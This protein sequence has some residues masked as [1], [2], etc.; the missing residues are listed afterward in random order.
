MSFQAP[1]HYTLVVGAQ[2]FAEIQ[3][4]TGL[5]EGRPV[6][7]VEVALDLQGLV[8]A[9]ATHEPS[10]VLLNPNLRNYAPDYVRDLLLR[11]GGPI[12]VVGYR[13]QDPTGEGAIMKKQGAAAFFEL[14][15][16]P[17][18]TQLFALIE[19]TYRKTWMAWKNGEFRATPDL[20]VSQPGTVKSAC[21]VPYLPKGG[22]SSRT[23]TASNLAAGLAALGHSTCLVDFDGTKGDVH[24]VFGYTIHPNNPLTPPDQFRLLDRT[25]YDLIME[26]LNNWEPGT[27]I[28]IQHILK[29]ITV[30]DGHPAVGRNLHLLA[31][32]T[33]PTLAGH[34]EW[35][36]KAKL[37]Y[38]LGRAILATLKTAYDFVIADVSQDYNQPLVGAALD[39]A[40]D[41]IMPVPPVRTALIDTHNA[42]P[43][44][45]EQYGSRSKIYWLAAMWEDG[46]DVPRIS[47][48][49]KTFQVTKLPIE[50]PCDTE[51]AR[52]A[53]NNCVPFVLTDNG[54]LGRG[55]QSLVGIYDPRAIPASSGSRMAGFFK[56]AGQAFVREA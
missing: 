1:D 37:I 25:L 46:P 19:E 10:L 33:R 40:T 44:L 42:L 38:Q 31:G 9:V 35:T 30:W 6:Q 41:I 36:S 47:T 55:M 8:D 45:I 5:L 29:Y 34:R 18:G 32:L 22:A 52:A 23:T 28:S 13:V 2:S 43:A 48:I 49:A 7:I 14:S 21:I 3:A 54:P 26:L 39:E 15:R 17:S 4:L 16:M 56:R 27:P 50:I 12:P 20:P 53:I 24:T 51:V 11:E